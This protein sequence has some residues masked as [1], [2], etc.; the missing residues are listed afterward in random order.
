[1]REPQ[2]VVESKFTKRELTN[3]T[4]VQPVELNTFN[5]GMDTANKRIATSPQRQQCDLMGAG[6]RS[7]C[8]VFDLFRNRI[9]QLEKEISKKD[10]MISFLTEQLSFKNAFIISSNSLQKQS[11]EGKSVNNPLNN[12]FESEIPRKEAHTNKL[13]KNIKVIVTGESLLNGLSEKGLSRNRYVTFKNFPG[14]TSERILEEMENLVADKP[15]CMILPTIV[16][17]SNE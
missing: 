3:T 17:D 14:G 15:A 12:S 13:N 5:K 11:Q 8:F 16:I 2:V 4:P 9:S 10:E 1:M 6:N 7:D